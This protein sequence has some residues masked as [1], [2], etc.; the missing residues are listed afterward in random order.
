MKLKE[1]PIEKEFNPIIA[2][3]ILI[4][5]IV[6]VSIGIAVWVGSLTFGDTTKINFHAQIYSTNDNIGVLNERAIFDISI[7]NYLNETRKFSI[8]VT[9]E[10]GQVYNETVELSRLEK[11]NMV[12]N[13]RLRFTGS[14]TIKVFEGNKQWYDY[15]FITFANNEEADLEITRIDQINSNNNLISNFLIVA[16][17]ILILGVVIF[18]FLKI[19]HKKSIRILLKK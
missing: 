17:L 3:I 7:E 15:S 6:I 1:S 10:E 4:V 14:W 11:R 18:L 2:S 12:V 19:H 13:Q 16:I 8:F 5:V 9:A